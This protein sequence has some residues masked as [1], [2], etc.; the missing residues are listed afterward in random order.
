MQSPR[1]TNSS[2]T[3]VQLHAH[4]RT[5]THTHTHARARTHARTFC[6]HTHTQNVSCAQFNNYLRGEGGGKLAR[7]CRDFNNLNYDLVSMITSYACVP[8]T[9][10]TRHVALIVRY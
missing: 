10:K 5:H 8:A 4:T 3:N 2:M 6:T 7:C 9:T 1:L